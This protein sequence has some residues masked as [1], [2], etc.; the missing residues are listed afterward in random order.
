MYL[1]FLHQFNIE[2][3]IEQQA[4]HAPMANPQA[5]A[6]IPFRP[7]S[8]NG[9]RTDSAQQWWT[10]FIRYVELSGI[11]DAQRPNVLGLLLS[12]TA[13]LWFD[14]LEDAVRND[15]GR[16]EAAFREKYIVPGPTALQRQMQT[17]QRQQ[18]VNESADDYVSDYQSKMRN[19]GYDDNLQMTLILNGLRPEIKAIVM[20]HLPFADLDALITKVKHVES[21]LRSSM[22]SP[23]VPFANAASTQASSLH[24]NAVIEESPTLTLKDVEAAISRALQ[25]LNSRISHAYRPRYEPP[26]TFNQPG[27]QQRPQRFQGRGHGSGSPLRCFICNS[28]FH[29]KRDCPENGARVAIGRGA[30]AQRSSGNARFTTS[31]GARTPQFGRNFNQGN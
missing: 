22:L 20:Q 28:K 15:F 18:Q 30:P 11:P 13:Q 25:P 17:L 21:A 4:P 6:A 1:D 9:L 19:F 2:P 23:N 31:R 16:L 8:Y 14:G 5:L 26:Q 24:S 12:G 7:A 10:N 3:E 29:L 27:F